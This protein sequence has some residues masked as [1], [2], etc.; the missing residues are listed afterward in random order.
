[1]CGR[2]VLAT[3]VTELQRRFGFVELPNLPP[4]YN[5]APT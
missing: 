1:M 2:Y 3:P 5:V 4:S